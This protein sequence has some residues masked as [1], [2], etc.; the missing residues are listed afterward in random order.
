LIQSD[1]RRAV[2]ASAARKA[3]IDQKLPSPSGRRPNSDGYG[4]YDEA[5]IER[6]KFFVW[7]YSRQTKNTLYVLGVS[8]VKIVFWTSMLFLEP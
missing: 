3:V 6:T 8:A 5:S 1:L 2:A 7:R 4:T